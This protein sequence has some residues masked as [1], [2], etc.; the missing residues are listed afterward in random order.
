M[1]GDHRRAALA[2]L[3]LALAL[4]LAAC[5]G[6]DSGGV[7]YEVYYLAEQG[8]LQDAAL[9]SQSLF[10]PEGE[11][12]IDL[13]LEALLQEPPAESMRRSIPKGVTLRGWTLEEGV[14]TV[15]FSRQ[16]G[17]LSGIELTLADYSVTM[18]LSQLSQVQSVVT[19]V[20]SEPISYRDHQNLRPEDLLLS[21]HRS[22]LTE[23]EI[24]LWFLL[25]TEEGLRWERRTKTILLTQDE[26]LALAALHALTAE[27]KTQALLGLPAEKDIHSV[28]VKDGC[29]IMDLSGSFFEMLPEE[30]AQ[31]VAALGALVLTLCQL[32]H[33][34]ALC[35][36]KEG[37]PALRYGQLGLAERLDA[38]SVQAFSGIAAPTQASQPED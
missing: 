14:L 8:G 6:R 36:Y 29:C 5:G 9:A 30:R 18:T 16:Y 19:R 20:E 15:D 21:L 25:E 22:A 34:D 3:T 7:Y 35:L 2:A 32:D 27:A 10:V 13:L 31:N 12:P 38:E 28:R 23:R 4:L 1:R 26:S 37:E 17:A 24:T 33:I 11:E